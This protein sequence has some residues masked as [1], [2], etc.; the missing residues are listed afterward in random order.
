MKTENVLK[1]VQQVGEDEL[2]TGLACNDTV[3]VHVS[4]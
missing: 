1:T 4:V 2:E 3:I